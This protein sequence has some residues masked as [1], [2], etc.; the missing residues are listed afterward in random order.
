VETERSGSDRIRACDGPD[1]ARGY[2]GDGQN[3]RENQRGL[4]QGRLHFEHLYHLVERWAA[5]SITS[6]W[7]F[8]GDRSSVAQPGCASVFRYART[9]GQS[10]VEFALLLPLIFLLILNIVNFGGFFFAWIT[11]ANGARAGAQ[12]MTMGTATV[13][14]APT[15]T[16]AQVTA[17][18]TDDISSL[19]NRSSLVVRVCTNNNGTIACTGS[20]SQTPPADPEPSDYILGSVDVTYTYVPFI[21]TWNMTNL[22][23]LLTLPPTKIH[24]RAVMRMQQ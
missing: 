14:N 18:V 16:T 8:E 2:R 4:R 13:G 10:L 9:S 7:N 22:G 6:K 21:S 17:L 1:C 12:Y 19:L 15:A 20:G 23:V 24:Q 3:C 5:A 11:V